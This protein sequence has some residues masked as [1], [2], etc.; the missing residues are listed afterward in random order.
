M[1]KTTEGSGLDTRQK[2]KIGLRYEAPML[3]SSKGQKGVF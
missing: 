2:W 3:S 1:N